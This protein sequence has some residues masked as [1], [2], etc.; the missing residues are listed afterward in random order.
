VAR[1]RARVDSGLGWLDGRVAFRRPCG[2]ATLALGCAL[3]W[4]VFR[5]Q[6]DLPR[7]PGLTT[8][9]EAWTVSRIGAGTEPG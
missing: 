4:M 1:Q 5:A 7:L 8:F 3:D 6:I 2:V 9:R